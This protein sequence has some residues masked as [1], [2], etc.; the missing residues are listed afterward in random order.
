VVDELPQ[1][2]PHGPLVGGHPL[3][4]SVGHRPFLSGQGLLSAV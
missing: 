4:F 2:L 3:P 1:V